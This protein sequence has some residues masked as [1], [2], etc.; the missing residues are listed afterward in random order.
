M[1]LSPIASLLCPFGDFFASAFKRMMGV[2]D[3]SKA[4][5]GHGGFTDRFDSTFMM[6]IVS[7][8]YFKYFVQF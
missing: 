7:G 1:I 6:L 5:P 2:K 3:F 4:I 8:F